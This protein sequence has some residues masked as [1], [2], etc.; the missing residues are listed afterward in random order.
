[1]YQYDH[2]LQFAKNKKNKN[3]LADLI[4]LLLHQTVT[5]RRSYLCQTVLKLQGEEVTYVT[6]TGRGSLCQTVTGEVVTYVK[7]LQG[8]GGYL[9][10]MIKANFV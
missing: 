3:C 5:G 4:L 10:K 9:C 8:E 7:Q 2:V 6:V 1:M